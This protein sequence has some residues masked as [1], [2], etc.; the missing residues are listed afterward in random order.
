VTSYA[1]FNKQNKNAI[2]AVNVTVKRSRR[3]AVSSSN[4]T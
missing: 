3:V 2:Y 4:Y 1:T